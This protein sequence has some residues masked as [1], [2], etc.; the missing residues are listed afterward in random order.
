MKTFVSLFFLCTWVTVGN[1]W[2]PLLFA[3]EAQSSGEAL[4]TVKSA[5][6]LQFE[7]PDDWPI[8]KVIN[9]VG[10]VSIEEYLAIKF[11]ESSA[12]MD[13][14]IAR[15]SE[16]ENRVEGLEVEH[17]KRTSYISNAEATT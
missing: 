11:R 12:Q 7:L 8:E 2:A 4:T 9:R 17:P 10:P 1:L 3:E 15:I 14:A 16:L 13:E 6:G 5:K